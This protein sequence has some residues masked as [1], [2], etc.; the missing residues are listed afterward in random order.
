VIVSDIGHAKARVRG[1]TNLRPAAHQIMQATSA[2][3]S[4][5]TVIRQRLAWVN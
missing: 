4:I 2:I 1:T 5:A 3:M